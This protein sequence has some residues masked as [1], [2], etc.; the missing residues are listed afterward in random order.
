MITCPGGGPDGHA[1]CEHLG[2]DY[3]V[4]VAS[5]TPTTHFECDGLRSASGEAA[6]VRGGR[7]N[8]SV[9]AARWHHEGMDSEE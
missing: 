4:A 6:M 3:C 9:A 8:G 1:F 2:C 5:S 7:Q